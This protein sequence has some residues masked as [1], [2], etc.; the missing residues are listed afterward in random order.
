VASYSDGFDRANDPDDLGANWTTDVGELN[1]ASNQC[2]CVGAAI[3]AARYTAGTL[4]S[5]NHYSQIDYISGSVGPHAIARQAS[6]TQ[7]YYC[8][9]LGDTWST[10]TLYKVVAGAFTALD[11]WGRTTNPSDTG[12]VECNGS[13]IKG[14]CG[15]VEV[16]S[17]SNSDITSGLYAGVGSNWSGRVLDNWAAADLAAGTRPLPQKAL[18]GPFAGPL[19]GPL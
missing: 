9:R 15:G 8:I 3:D 12:K 4:A 10:W 16:M 13:A 14:Y 5:A 6:A 1:I 11:T 19:G 18:G 7:T 2:S 17:D